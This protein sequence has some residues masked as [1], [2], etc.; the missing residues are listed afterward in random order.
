MG[1]RDLLL[2]LEFV[3]DSTSNVSLVGALHAVNGDLHFLVR[4][5]AVAGGDISGVVRIMN[6]MDCRL[7]GDVVN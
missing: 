1:D 6:D 2:L 5:S 7:D 4:E 3:A